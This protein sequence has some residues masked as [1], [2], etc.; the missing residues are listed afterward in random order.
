M[1]KNPRPSVKG[2]TRHE[3]S[4]NQPWAN[5]W[6]N[7]PPQKGRHTSN[8]PPNHDW[9]YLPAACVCG[10]RAGAKCITINHYLASSPA[11]SWAVSDFIWIRAE[12]GWGTG[13]EITRQGKIIM[14]G[15]FGPGNHA[16][17]CGFVTKTL[18]SAP[19]NTYAST[20]RALPPWRHGRAFMRW[21]MSCCLPSHTV[22][23]TQHTNTGGNDACIRSTNMNLQHSRSGQ[24]TTV[25]S[26]ESSK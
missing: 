13:E 16:L 4:N 11:S 5:K 17:S 25:R 19:S 15:F 26:L 7:H 8:P 2:D 6:C 10:G 22:A 23:R 24:N 3:L 21:T 14:S 18:T 1:H 20:R 9:F 12:K